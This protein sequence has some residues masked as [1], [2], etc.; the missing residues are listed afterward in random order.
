[1]IINNII[2]TVDVPKTCA[3]YFVIESEAD[4]LVKIDFSYLLIM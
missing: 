1:M 3:K 2:V 4:I